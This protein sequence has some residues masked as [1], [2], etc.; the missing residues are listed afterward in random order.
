MN[1]NI[2]TAQKMKFSIKGFF[3]KCDQIRSFLRIW[4]HLQKK[5]LMENLIFCAVFLHFLLEHWCGHNDL[6]EIIFLIEPILQQYSWL[7]QL[8]QY[9]LA[10]PAM[11][12]QQLSVLH[13]MKNLPTL[14]IYRVPQCLCFSKSTQ[15]QVSHIG[16]LHSIRLSSS[17]IRQRIL[18]EMV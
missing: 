11:V 12:S 17:R 15:L 18:V 14:E 7:A 16:W 10:P 5:S 13:W 2:S 3:S 8:C 9:I 6:T 1:K 4:S